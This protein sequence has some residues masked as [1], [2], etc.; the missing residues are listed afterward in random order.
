MSNHDKYRFIA[1]WI[2]LLTYLFLIGLSTLHYHHYE[3]DNRNILSSES[4]RSSVFNDIIQDYTGNCV[5]HHFSN[6]LLNYY[7]SSSEVTKI[8]PPVSEFPK[9]PVFHFYTVSIFSSPSLRAP[10]VNS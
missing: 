5:V 6:T 9:A 3:I 7:F 2:F 10:P 4:P 8:K 1:V